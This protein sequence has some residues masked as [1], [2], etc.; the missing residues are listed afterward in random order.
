MLGVLYAVSAISQP[1][2][3]G[4]KTRTMFVV[5]LLTPVLFIMNYML[6]HSERQLCTYFCPTFMHFAEGLWTGTANRNANMGPLHSNTMTN[7][8]LKFKISNLLMVRD[9]KP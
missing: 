9:S 2:N 1:Y 3:G 4:K 7:I 5:K 6:E 8:Y